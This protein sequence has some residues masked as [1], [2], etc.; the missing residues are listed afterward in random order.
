MK[1]AIEKL[2]TVNCFFSK[3]STFVNET[4][5][6]FKERYFESLLQ[7]FFYT[8][9]NKKESRKMYFRTAIKFTYSLALTR[10]VGNEGG[11]FVR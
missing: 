6:Q 9:Q 8:K 2:E 11:Y 4:S 10:K 7:R 1:Q 5:F 3:M